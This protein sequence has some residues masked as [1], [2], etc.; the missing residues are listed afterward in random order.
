VNTA[1]RCFPNSP[2]AVTFRGEAVESQEMLLNPL[3]NFLVA[4]V[5]SGPHIFVQEEVFAIQSTCPVMISSFDEVECDENEAFRIA[6]VVI[7]LTL[8]A[9]ATLIVC[10]TAVMVV[11]R[12]LRGW[13]FSKRVST[14]T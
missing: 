11:Y 14:R 3:Q 5:S 12:L 8:V 1:F 13:I 2:T 7:V 9:I 6:V 10:F 4:W